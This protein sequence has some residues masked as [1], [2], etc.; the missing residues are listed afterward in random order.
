MDGL[1]AFNAI[2]SHETFAQNT[3]EL[4]A[5]F[6]KESFNK[7]KAAAK[8][9]V[10]AFKEGKK[11]E[12]TQKQHFFSKIKNCSKKLFI[13]AMRITPYIGVLGALGCTI[14]SLSHPAAAAGIPAFMVLTKVGIYYNNRYDQKQAAKASLDAKL[15]RYQAPSLSATEEAPEETEGKKKEPKTD[16][17]YLQSQFQNI[18]S[19][20]KNSKSKE[21]THELIDLKYKAL[22][23]LIKKEAFPKKELYEISDSDLKSQT[24]LEIRILEERRIREMNVASRRFKNAVPA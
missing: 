7:V 14:A 1:S 9:V 21:E 3:S 8:D 15:E 16:I 19:Q 6:S 17:P 13:L 10:Q 5:L 4:K 12:H 18:Q 22:K 20:M 2:V 11:P 24:K 23:S